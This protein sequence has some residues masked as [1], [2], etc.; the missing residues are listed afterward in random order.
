MTTMGRRNDWT[1]A[2][3]TKFNSLLE[4]I[5]FFKKRLTFEELN[6]ITLQNFM[7]SLRKEGLRNT[8]ISKYLSFFRWFLRWAYYKGYNPTT[9][10]E[11]F[12][13]KLKGTDGNAKEVI[14]LEWEELL[15]LYTFNFSA[16]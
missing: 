15:S 1:P 5:K 11:T 3:Y 9:V 8:T 2:T 10:H 4:H 13:P 7:L 12:K 6:E 14:Y 16:R